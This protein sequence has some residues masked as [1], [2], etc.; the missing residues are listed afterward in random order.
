MKNYLSKYDFDFKERER[1]KQTDPPPKKK[2]TTYVKFNAKKDMD[3]TLWLLNEAPTF[4][5]VNA[6]F[7]NLR[8]ILRNG[9]N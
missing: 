5:E 3:Q 7:T 8:A 4:T 2:P 1:N 6:E 9:R